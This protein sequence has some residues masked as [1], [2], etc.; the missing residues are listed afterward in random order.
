MLC[1]RR[2]T[3]DMKIQRSMERKDTLRRAGH[4]AA[5]SATVRRRVVFAS[6]SLTRFPSSCFALFVCLDRPSQPPHDLI[7][8]HMSIHLHILAIPTCVTIST[9]CHRGCTSVLTFYHVRVACSR[10]YAFR[11]SFTSSRFRTFSFSSK[12]RLQKRDTC[13]VRPLCLSL[14][15][16]SHPSAFRLSMSFLQ[17]SRVQ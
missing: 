8:T 1:R 10:H 15:S 3:E 13:R 9:Q 14:C 4:M 11:H 6:C 2:Q 7:L 12:G 5:P 17:T 16:S